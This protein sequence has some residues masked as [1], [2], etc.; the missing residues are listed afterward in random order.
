MLADVTE[1]L[2]IYGHRYIFEICARRDSP[3]IFD[4]LSGRAIQSCRI[5]RFRLEYNHRDRDND[6][7]FAVQ[8]FF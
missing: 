1:R 8:T 4:G 2:E 3:T 5:G 6:L 7:S